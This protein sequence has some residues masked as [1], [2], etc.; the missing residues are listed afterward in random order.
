MLQI[1]TVLS[2]TGCNLYRGRADMGDLIQNK[3]DVLA[4]Q[5]VFPNAFDKEKL[6]LRDTR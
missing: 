1:E 3:P 6:K 5:E 2:V 4:L